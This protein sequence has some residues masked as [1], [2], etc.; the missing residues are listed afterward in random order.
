MTVVVV[1]KGPDPSV[2][3]KVV[4]PKC[5]ATLE[6][7]PRDVQRSISHDY[8]GGSDVRSYIRCP[9]CKEYIDVKDR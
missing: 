5:G 9:E 8:D 6:Y 3:R 1:D 2:V 7:T 4:C